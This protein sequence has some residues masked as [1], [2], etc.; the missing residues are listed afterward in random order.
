MYPRHRS[1]TLEAGRNRVANAPCE[2]PSGA[3]GRIGRGCISPPI[4]DKIDSGGSGEL[5]GYKNDFHEQTSEG[6]ELDFTDLNLI[7]IKD[8]LTENNQIPSL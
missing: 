6:S 3:R 7:F 8:S 4:S 1:A 2:D 5:T